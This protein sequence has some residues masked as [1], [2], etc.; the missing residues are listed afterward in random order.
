MIL[1][2]FRKRTA[3]SNSQKESAKDKRVFGEQYSENN[4]DPERKKFA[5]QF[6]TPIKEVL[7]LTKEGTTASRT[8][9]NKLWEAGVSVLAYVDVATGELVKEKVFL[10]WQLTEEERRDKRKL[11]GIEGEKIYHL[12]VKESLPFVNPY[13]GVE[14]KA[15]SRL[16][17]QE[18]VK[19][20]CKDARLEE[21]L[22][23]FQK[24]VELELRDGVRLLLNKKVNTFYGM[25]SWNGEKCHVGLDADAD[26]GLMAQD[27][28]D[29]YYQIMADCG[30][31]DEKARSYAAKYLT[32][33]ANDWQEEEAE[34]ITK[35]EFAKRLK[36]SSLNIMDEGCFEIF[37][38]DD[39]MFY[40]HVIIVSG[41]LENGIDDAQIAG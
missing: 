2:V 20:N 35:E 6:D 40:G 1:G 15:G 34:E 16:W 18:V 28:A 38:D 14:M 4:T 33:N 22:K 13:S 30:Q 9:Q 11:F 7:V 24:P 12:K 19:H 37:Y 31:W 5:E 36:I 27:V 3:K 32:D 26:S 29:T 39:D 17:V 10:K 21:I 25:G 23:E 8:G 41:S